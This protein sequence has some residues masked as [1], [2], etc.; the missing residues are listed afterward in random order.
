MACGNINE[1]QKS[2]ISTES[3]HLLSESINCSQERQEVDPLK[4]ESSSFL[5]PAAAAYLAFRGDRTSPQP[6]SV[7]LGAIPRTRAASSSSRDLSNQSEEVSESLPANLQSE[8]PAR[9]QSELQ[10]TCLPANLQSEIPASQSEVQ[11][12]C[13]L[14]CRRD[15]PVDDQ[16]RLITVCNSCYRRFQTITR[17]LRNTDIRDC[18]RETRIAVSHLK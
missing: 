16:N 10:Q 15:L 12:R 2:V 6:V 4:E 5:H 7:N 14:L 8:I 11:P 18:N 13:G 17:T 9:P 3:I 1:R